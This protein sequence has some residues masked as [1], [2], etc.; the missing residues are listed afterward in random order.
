[1]GIDDYT[2]IVLLNAIFD[3]YVDAKYATKYNSDNINVEIVVNMI[4]TMN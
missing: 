1:M 4:K 3:F 2:Y